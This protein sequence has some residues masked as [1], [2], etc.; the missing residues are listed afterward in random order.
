MV[1]TCLAM[2]GVLTLIATRESPLQS[3]EAAETQSLDVTIGYIIASPLSIQFGQLATIS[4]RLE[5]T[6]TRTP[7]PTWVPMPTE[8]PMLYCYAATPPPDGTL[9]SPKSPT[10]TPTLEPPQQPNPTPES[11]LSTPYAGRSPANCYWVNLATPEA[12]GT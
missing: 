11:C 12:A 10:P 9:C 6:A 2:A 5:P 7:R 4:A 8:T 3:P 1:A